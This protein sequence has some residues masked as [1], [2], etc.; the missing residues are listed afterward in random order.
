MTIDIQIL[1]GP[2]P[3]SPEAPPAPGAGALVRFRGIVREQ[4][5]QPANAGATRPI[6]AID[7]EVYSPMAEREL[8]RL[9]EALA[10][11][12]GL[13]LVRV[14]HSRGRVPVGDASFELEV[15]APHRAPALAAMAEFIDRMKQD[16]P[17][18]K[19]PVWAV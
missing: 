5:P 19:S 4:E 18:W 17:I 13:L 11:R 10:I 2:V 3:P 12:H 9:A 8:H 15:A 6:A 16:A 7:Y 14:R 1:E